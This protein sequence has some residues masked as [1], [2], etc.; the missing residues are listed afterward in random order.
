MGVK[1]DYIN[2]MVDIIKRMNPDLDEDDIRKA[3]S[4]VVKQELKDP[5]ITMDNNVT[6][7]Y[8]E[9]TL[10]KMCEWIDRTNPVISGNATFYCQPEVLES[11]TSN[12]LR[13]LKKGRKTVKNEMQ[14]LL[15][16]RVLL[17]QWLHSLNHS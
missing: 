13:S 3:V 4:S 9:I 7:E 8:H 6:G 10:T 2:N 1:K 5:T 12:M 11:P 14:Q 16:R 15:W 17:L